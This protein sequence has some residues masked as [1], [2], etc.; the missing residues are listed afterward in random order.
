MVRRERLRDTVEV[1]AFDIYETVLA[2]RPAF[3]P[4]FEGFLDGKDSEMGPDE[5]LEAWQRTLVH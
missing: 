3:V 2:L 4:A 5:L 1:V